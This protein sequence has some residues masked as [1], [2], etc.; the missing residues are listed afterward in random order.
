[1]SKNFHGVGIGPLS[2]ILAVKWTVN[3]AMPKRSIDQFQPVQL[4]NVSR[5]YCPN[6]YIVA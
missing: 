6:V 2:K 1:M 5:A 4:K 3:V